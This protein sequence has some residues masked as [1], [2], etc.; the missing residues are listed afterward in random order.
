MARGINPEESCDSFL[1]AIR[2]GSFR[3]EQRRAGVSHLL[4]RHDVQNVPVVIPMAVVIP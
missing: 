1:A 2:N 4:G 3:F